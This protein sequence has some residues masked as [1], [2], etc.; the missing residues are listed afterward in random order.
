MSLST[1]TFLLPLILLPV[2]LCIKWNSFISKNK[3]NLP[4]SPQ[5]FPIIGNMHQL[6]SNPSRS[7]QALSR[8]Y[9]PIMLI[10]LGR[11][12]TLVASSA[13]VAREIMKTHD[14]SFCSRP[15]LRVPNILM[16]GSKDIVFSPY[17]E[18]W[19]Q[20]KSIVVVHLL[21]NS[22]VKSFQKVREK[23]T[24]LIIRKLEESCGCSLD[25]RA[26]LIS[27]SNNLICRVAAGRVYDGLKLT[28]LLKKH[29]HL[30]TVFTIG[31]Y[32]PWLSWVDQ[33]SGIE[34]RAREI[35]KEVDEFL[36]GVVKEHV[37][38]YT[39]ANAESD[40]A[41]DLIDIL[42]GLQRDNTIDFTFHKD[43]LKAV[44]WDMFVGGTDTTFTALEWVISELIKQPRVMKKL[45]EELTEVAQGRSKILE[46][47]L[48]KMKYLKAVIK[49]ALRLHPPVP[50]LIPRESTQDIKLMGY[51]IPVGTQAI[52]NAW[53]IGR[54]PVLWEDP[55]VFWPERFLNNFIN[56]KGIHFEWLPF[57]SGRRQCPGIQFGVVAI[58]LALANII[59][60]F[61]FTLPNG[62]KNEDLDMSEESGLTLCRKS[63]LMVIASSRT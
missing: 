35:A 44:V 32:V 60:K 36:D 9:G 5:K 22:R 59:Y 27:F 4:P 3:K 58:E 43:T 6:G 57:G 54:D 17:G 1:Q 10:Y 39:G 13:E 25:L 53:A 38:K 45:Q 46:E 51:D 26:L 8:K 62:V 29:V 14:S 47:D 19:R 40:K 23:E 21:S 52:I 55:E 24:Q 56:Y 49:E 11:K 12:P 30:L 18:Y 61:N 15:N 42:L 37:D 16:Y 33:V 48:E 20:L 7:F 63:S 34:R 41:Q 31:S 50:L 28:N 2:F